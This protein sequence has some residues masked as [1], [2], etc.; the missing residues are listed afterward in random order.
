MAGETAVHGTVAEGFQEVREE[1]AA[2]AAEERADYAAQLVAYAGGE[3]VVDLWTGPDFDGDTLVGVFSSTKGAAHLTVALLVQDG[4]L[5]PDERVSHYW[6]EFGA[7]GK[8]DITL[9]DLLSHRAGLVG[10]DTGFTLAELADDRVIAERLAAQRPYWR[11][12]TAFGYHALVIGAL[13]G[14]VVRRVTGQ[15]LQEVYESRIRAPYDLD[16]YMGLPQALEPRVRAVQPMLPT[17]E[18]QAELDAAAT[19]AYGLLGIAFNLNHPTEPTDLQRLFDSPVIRA[20]GPASVGG[21]ASARGLAKMYAAAI[22]EVDGRAPLLKPDTAAAFAQIHS[23]GHDLVAGERG[24]YGLGFTVV[25]DEYSFL[26]QGAF[27]HSGAGGSLAFAD[28]RSGLAYGY[29]RRRYAFPGGA[30]PENARLARAVHRAVT[31]RR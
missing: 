30:A 14:E 19:G 13:T 28:P 11:P 4:T 16:F 25:S 31:G 18:Q 26:G 23:A 21:I 3:R 2:F 29:S 7:E 9:R 22:G 10:A 12:G 1:F 17:P 8:Q 15:T 24:V 20:A 27:G 5:D 6:P